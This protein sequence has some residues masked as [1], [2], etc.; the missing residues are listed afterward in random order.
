MRYIIYGILYSTCWYKYLIYFHCFILS[1]KQHYAK[2]LFDVTHYVYG[3]YREEGS[4]ALRI[5]DSWSELYE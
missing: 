3:E 1:T 4:I 5:S 2:H